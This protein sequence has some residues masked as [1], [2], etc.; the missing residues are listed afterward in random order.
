VFVLEH[1]KPL[2]IADALAEPWLD[3]H[4]ARTDVRSYCGVPLAPAVGGMVGTLCHYDPLPHAHSEETLGLLLAFGALLAG[5]PE[6]AAVA[7]LSASL[8]R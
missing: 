8:R 3:G 2:V 5:R 6:I 7:N 4:A 1:K